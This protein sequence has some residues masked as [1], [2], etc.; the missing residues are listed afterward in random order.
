M[1]EGRKKEKKYV[2]ELMRPRGGDEAE[3]MTS[4]RRLART[5]PARATLEEAR[6]VHRRTEDSGILRWEGG[7][8]IHEPHHTQNI[9]VNNKATGFECF[10]TIHRLVYQA[11]KRLLL[12]PIFFFFLKET[13]EYISPN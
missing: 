1:K 2:E 4:E 11:T 3:E 5:G 7:N 12:A 6:E 13:K 9:C 8:K 10:K